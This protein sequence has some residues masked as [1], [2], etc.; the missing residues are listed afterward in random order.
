MTTE[1]PEPQT[2][3]KVDY[4]LTGPSA[5]KA[6]AR[7][8]AGADWYQSPVP[9]KAM[10]ELLARKDG[11]A[12]RDT[13]LLFVILLITAIATILLWGTYWVIAPY[14]VYAVFYG[15]SSDS[16]WHEC[17]HGTAFRTDWLNNLVY[18]IASFMV[19][20]ESIVWRWSHIRHHSDTIIVGRDPEIQIPRP[21]NL[22][23][24]LFS[25]VNLEGYKT[26]YLSL[27][28]HSFGNISA[29]EKT[30]VPESEY[31]KIYSN[32]RI[33]LALYLL[34][35]ISAVALQSWIPIFLF[36]LPQFFGNWLMIIHNTTQHAGLAENVLDHRLNCRTV[37]MNP[38]S[39]FIYWNMNY[40]VEH[41]MFPLV[42]Y[43]ALP[44]LH[45]LVKEDCPPVYPSILSAWKEIVP[46]LLKQQK[47]PGYHIK[48][49]L[50]AAQKQQR[51]NVIESGGVFNNYGW[52]N[53]GAS[54]LLDNED[55]IRFNHADRTFAVYRDNEGKLYATDGICTHGN[56]H[57]SEGL[58]K[59]KIIECPKHNGRFN[60]HDGSP[61]RAPVCR[62]LVTYAIKEDLGHLW[63]NL[64]KS[65]GVDA[66]KEKT[67][68]FAVISNK[69]VATFIKELIVTPIDDNA[70]IS[71]TPGD[72]LQIQIPRYAE[73][74][75][76]EF[77]IEEPYREV[78]QAHGLF[79]LSSH[80]PKPGRLNNY[81]L[82]SNWK[83]GNQ[84]VF[85]VRIATPPPGQDC[86]PG[87]GTSY[88]FNLKP[89]DVITALGPF[90]D[91]YI[92]PTQKEMVYIGGGAG[93]A[94]IRAHIAHLLEN[95][96]SQRKISYW[97]GARAKQE[98]FYLDYFQDL[99]AAHPNF[100]FQC[101]LSNSVEDDTWN[102]H[103]GFIH[104]V[105]YHNY[106]KGH[107]DIENVEFYLCGPPMMMKA[108]TKMLA[109]IGVKANQITFD[110]F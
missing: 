96:A 8:L 43:H 28:R 27:I 67:Y 13:L 81:S 102:G 72:Y 17:G 69:N 29:T 63:L 22:K 39:R 101:A 64:K 110:Q 70:K 93:M 52:L 38:I 100:N 9:H 42:P 46:T 12:I 83:H 16:R 25:L 61:A 106:L 76:S 51:S 77:Q 87:V 66:V 75:F 108:A 48:R 103:Y 31:Q 33:C 60:L 57:L 78:W 73:I 82:A 62:G 24:L 71:F 104:D 26:Y 68:S 86:Q 14:L 58:V 23:S 40:H 59:G 5:E 54:T 41:H 11:P 105:A 98:I 15:T 49:K 94:P 99:A 20:R 53:I 88:I 85:N 74:Q 89:G 55:V 35:I 65:G 95:D 7:G 90:G 97:Y 37:Y 1:I 80:N 44:S 45:K 36:M 56:T 4:S 6:V 47:D 3:K 2:I 92:K 30:Y 19:M 32:A 79:N 91:F 50:P 109:E 10:R 34:I 18:E 84:L 107:N 21:P